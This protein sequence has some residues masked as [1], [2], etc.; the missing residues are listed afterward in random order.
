LTVIISILHTG[1]EEKYT[2]IITCMYEYFGYRLIPTLNS[3]SCTK[4]EPMDLIVKYLISRK[5]IISYG[6][7]LI[8]K[9][10]IFD[11][12]VKYFLINK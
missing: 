3:T 5:K 2:H 10:R 9:N 4:C 7:H 8:I 12:V 1:I 11:K 6:K